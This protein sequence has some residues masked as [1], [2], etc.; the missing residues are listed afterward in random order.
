MSASTPKAT[1]GVQVNLMVSRVF[2][3]SSA[4][5]AHAAAGEIPNARSVCGITVEQS[6]SEKPPNAKAKEN[7][8]GVSAQLIGGESREGG[9]EGDGEVKQTLKPPLTTQ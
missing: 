6:P 7:G 8:L 1:G 2:M 9:G 4:V 3:T 5:R